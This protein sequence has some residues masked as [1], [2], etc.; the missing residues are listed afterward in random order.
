MAYLLGETG[1]SAASGISF[2]VT[3]A[4]V[5]S[6]TPGFSSVFL[7]NVDQ[8]DPLGAS[9]SNATTSVNTLAT[10][11]LPAAEGDLVVVAATC[12]N[13][14]SYSLNNG[15][16]EHV[17]LSLTSM[18]AVAGTRSAGGP[19]ETPSVTHSNANRQTIIGL[20]LQRE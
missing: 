12:G 16:T 7:A 20:V 17:E 18:D 3:W 6:A 15:F 13:T 14:G 8:S 5:P 9:D 4:E 11:A 19:A 10:A 1:I 2:A